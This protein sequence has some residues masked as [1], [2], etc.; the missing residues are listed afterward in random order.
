[1]RQGSLGVL[2]DQLTGGDQ[3]AGH[4][5]GYRPGQR[6]QFGAHLGVERVRAD[7]LVERGAA[8]PGFAVAL[9]V[10]TLTGVAVAVATVPGVAVAV[11]TLTGGRRPVGRRSTVGRAALAGR[12]TV[13]AR[14]SLGA[15]LEAPLRAVLTRT[16]AATVAA[17]PVVP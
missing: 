17:R 3:S 15:L 8:V 5:L 1:V 2:V 12:A 11:A 6:P 13:K 10:A 14:G 7:A 16:E 9:A 4:R